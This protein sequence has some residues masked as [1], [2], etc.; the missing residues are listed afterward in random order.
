MDYRREVMTPISTG[1]NVVQTRPV[2][3][4]PL[5]ARYQRYGSVNEASS[6]ACRKGFGSG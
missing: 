6:F 5:V 3:M 4:Y 1:G 2:C